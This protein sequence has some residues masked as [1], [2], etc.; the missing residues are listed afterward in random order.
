MTFNGHLIIVCVMAALFLV[1]IT[2]GAGYSQGAQIAPVAVGL[3][4]LLCTLG[5]T[6]GRHESS[7]SRGSNHESGMKEFP[8]DL[9][10]WLLSLIVLVVLLGLIAGAAMFVAA[11]LRW[12][13]RRTW[14]SS[15]ATSIATTGFV[16]FVFEVLMDVLLFRGVL[17][18]Y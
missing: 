15:L 4:G 7:D 16:Y 3:V 8:V 12:R 5:E 1:V 2:V 10:L 17:Q 11:F 18:L 6:R 9:F 14:V 13:E